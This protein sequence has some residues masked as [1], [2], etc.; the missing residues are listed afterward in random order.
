MTRP[1]PTERSG[2]DPT[3][4]GRTDAAQPGKDEARPM[5]EA[6]AATADAIS[7]PDDTASFEAYRPL[8]F[9]IAYRMLGSVTEAEDIVQETY[10]RYRAAPPGSIRSLKSFLTTIVTRLCLDEL[11]SARARRESYFGPWLPEP[12][13][14]AEADARLAPGHRLEEY[15]SISMA[16]LVLLESL[17]PIERAVFL[18]R[19][20][21]DY[22]Y[23]E[24]AQIVGKRED[25]CRQIFR[26]AKQSIDERRPR[27][28]STPEDRQR[29][30][31]GFLRATQAGDLAGLTRLLAEDITLWADGGGKVAAA[32]R[33]LHG[34]DAV[35]RFILGLARKAPPETQFEVTQANGSPAI[36]VR[37][38]G[39][40]VA[41][42]SL[43]VNGDQ[44]RAIRSV[45]NPDKLR[46]L[47]QA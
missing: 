33:P 22:G 19:Q 4:S 12:L 37:L 23:P 20:V 3:S 27:F 11:K 1:L 46:H 13:L 6:P 18:L 16:F 26:R 34:R 32:T 28:R 25:T 2:S 21:F 42:L 41:V 40:P 15:E 7:A 47:R 43:E 36:I 45:V 35:A 30:T 5:V 31:V 17:T 10:L 9:S 39:S 38:G 14:S 44:I 24:I 8:L 29:L